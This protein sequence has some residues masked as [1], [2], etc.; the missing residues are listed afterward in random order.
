MKAIL[1]VSTL[2]LLILSLGEFSPHDLDFLK[3][4]EGIP[5][6]AAHMETRGDSWLQ[7]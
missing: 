3:N 6:C 1:Q 2:G 4:E 7:E 5:P